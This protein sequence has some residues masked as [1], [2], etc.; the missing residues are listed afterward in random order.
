MAA[1]QRDA[2]HRPTA[3]VVMAKAPV[4]GLAKTRLAPALGAAGAA[5]LAERFLSH[6][7]GE[8]LAAGLGAV[9]LSCA[10]D[11]RHAAFAAWARNPQLALETQADGDLGRRM[12][13]AFESAFRHAEAALLFGTDAPALDAALLARAAAALCEPGGHDAVFVPTLDGGYV[14]VGLSRRA[15]RTWPQ[16]GAAL[17]DDMPW[18]TSEVM[19]RTRERLQGLQARTLELPPLADVDEPP[20]LVHVPPAWLQQARRG[21]PG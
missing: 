1:G 3:L 13:A 2:V 4:P 20:D 7:L 5:R 9:T 8:A 18:S 21:R 12:A 10:P 11:A 16:G 15:W 17:F 6:A 14:L 19:P